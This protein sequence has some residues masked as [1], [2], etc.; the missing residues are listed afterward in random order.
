MRFLFYDRVMEL[1]KGRFIHGVKSFSLSEEFLRR[2][3]G[4][5]ALVP[6]VIMIEAMAQL[7]GWLIVYSLDF[8]VSAIM[9]L[10]EDVTV[11]PRLR[12]GFQAEIYGEIVSISKR[13]SLGSARMSVDGQTIASMNRIIYSHLHQVDAEELRRLFGYYSG[14]HAERVPR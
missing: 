8:K 13:D 9:S 5:I 6:G 2:H 10:V 4:K 1:E 11:P 3:Y 7:L 12:P 14:L